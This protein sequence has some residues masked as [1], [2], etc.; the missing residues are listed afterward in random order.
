MRVQEAQIAQWFASP[1]GQALSQAQSETVKSLLHA[2]LYFHSA[3]LMQGP[4]GRCGEPSA[5]VAVVS[6]RKGRILRC[7]LRYWHIVMSC[8]LRTKAWT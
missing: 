1:L 7:V 5:L 2:R 3:Q 8:H 6:F 4:I